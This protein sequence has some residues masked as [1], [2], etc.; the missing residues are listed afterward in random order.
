MVGRGFKAVRY[1]YFARAGH[2]D[3]VDAWLYP[4]DVMAVLGR[5]IT[6][7]PVVVTG[8]YN[9]R[10][11][12]RP[13]T[14]LEQRINALANRRVDAVVANS[15]AVAADALRHET[16]DPAKLR[17]IRNGVEPIEPLTPVEVESRRRAL[18]VANDELLVGCVANYQPVKRHDLLI[19]AFASLRRE[20]HK[21]RLLMVGEGPL[22]GELQ[23]QIDAYGLQDCARLH[24]RVT[25]PKPLL[26]LFD[27]VVQTSRSEGLPNALLEAAAAARPIVATA[28]GGS[29][30]IVI[31][32]DTGLLVP[33]NDVDGITAAMRRMVM[34]RDLRG[35][36]GLAARRR[37]DTTFRMSRFIGEYA[38]LY[39]EL[40]EAK[41]LLPG[42]S[43][44]SR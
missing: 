27:L 1:A 16:I 19:E 15:D 17:V 14:A 44:P 36:L 12:N 32:G 7:T 26:S 43:R 38:A 41:G 33:V 4:V 28:A 23:R 42:T 25:D 3:V 22:R 30:E 21:L 9:L 5:S 37:A 18:G 20:G 39:E 34:D 6:R 31:D 2:Y 11:F 24:G 40:A 29:G 8:R 35:R 10:D 13:M